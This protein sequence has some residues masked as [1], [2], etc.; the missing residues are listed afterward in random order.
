[1]TADRNLVAFFKVLL[2]KLSGFEI[3]VS[4]GANRTGLNKAEVGRFGE[5]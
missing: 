2:I 4:K 1:M 3:L 5:S